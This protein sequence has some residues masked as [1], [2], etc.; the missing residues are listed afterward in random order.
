MKIF[1]NIIF[2]FC[3]I[4][5]FLIS[6]LSIYSFFAIKD[7]TSPQINRIDEKVYTKIYDNSS[8]LIETLGENK[9]KF[10][11][12]DELPP[13]LIKALIS[14]EDNEFFYHNGI[15]YNRIIKSLFN[16]IFSSSKQGGSTITQQLVKNLVLTNEQT[17]K[18]KIQ[19][20][21]LASLL[22]QKLT[23]EEIIEFYFNEI[24]FEPT[25]PGISYAAKRFFNKEVS[26]LSL[27]ECAL[28]VGLV[29]SPSYYNP[30]NH[31]TR[32]NERKN[33]VLL[34]MKKN[35]YITLEQ[36][37]NAIKKDVSSFI[38]E[39][40]SFYQKENYAYQAYLDIVYSEIK[41]LTSLNPF[42]IPLEIETYLDTSLQSYLDNIQKG[43]NF[44]FIDDNQQIASCIINNNDASILG[45]IGGRNYDGMLLYN[46]A[47]QMLR[48]PAST[49]KPIFTYLLAIE[50]LSFN[51]YTLIEDKPYTYKNTNI[52]VQ[53]A[54]KKY[55]GMI[56]LVEA[57]GYSRNTSTLYTL[58][59]VINK[60]GQEKCID[61]LKN[62]NLMDEGEFA[63]PYA[64]GGMKYGVSLV[65][66][67]GAYSLLPRNGN[68][69]TPS[70]IKKIKRLDTNEIIY[71]RDLNGKQVISKEASYI[72]TSTLKKVMDNNYYN[73]AYTRP[74]NLI[75][76][77]KTGTNAYDEVVIKKYHYPSYADRDIWFCGYSK[78]Y[79]I[80]TWTGF[81]EPKENNKN[82]FGH[83]DQRRLVCKD[84][85]KLCINKLEIKNNPFNELSSINKVNIVKNV[86]GN[87]LPNELISKENIVQASFKK[88]EEPK[89]VLP[90]PYFKKIENPNI[91]LFNNKLEININYP[92]EDDELYQYL[93]GKRIF[94]VTYEDEN[95]LKTFSFDTNSFSIDLLS[96]TCS[97]T[98]VETFENNTKISGESYFLPLNLQYDFNLQPSQ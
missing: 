84:I 32:A 56:P 31:P 73:I 89:Q 43:S 54:D 52:T 42:S 4:F 87:Y 29:K 62:I 18:R 9:N 82:Y 28:L 27:P 71:Q 17:L 70:T 19:E 46:R 13:L 83:N 22:E 30:F 6:G 14:I 1:K 5:I 76:A 77:G 91:I 45:V 26:L 94:L 96:L 78:N 20:A 79:T 69:L 88:G 51:E 33:L 16:N 97:V 63:L 64:I 48:Q 11:S 59:K 55:L 68:Y 8:R 65:N 86:P 15:N 25:I 21:Y 36:Y 90:L 92:L 7:L 40:G 57:I 41:K 2:S 35:N 23:K 39:K 98:I 93:F 81:D 49:M 74:N 44:K 85:F 75:I 34:T 61:Y 53:N 58:E 10:V 3:L 50:Y 72:M 12:Y 60:I 38:I 66:L 80:A 24:Y 95:N 67:A 37:N 47:Y